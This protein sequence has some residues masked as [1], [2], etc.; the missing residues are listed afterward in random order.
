M[1]CTTHTHI[2]TYGEMWES[3]AGHQT[4]GPNMLGKCS[5]TEIH[6]P[7]FNF[8]ESK[9]TEFAMDNKVK[10]TELWF[11]SWQSFFSL[12]LNHYSIYLKTW[13]TEKH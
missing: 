3:G 9:N 5:T 6:S 12:A 1:I 13:T 7:V 2:Y 10:V 11:E 8:Y 4:Q